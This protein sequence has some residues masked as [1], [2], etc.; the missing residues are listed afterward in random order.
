MVLD[1]TRVTRRVH[2]IPLNFN[3]I[4]IPLNL[5]EMDAVASFSI[6]QMLYTDNKG[7]VCLEA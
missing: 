1:P 2:W 7:K 4:L 5:K 6:R 3:L